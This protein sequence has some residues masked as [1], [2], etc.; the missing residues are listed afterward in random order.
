M[1][2]LVVGGHSFGGGTAIGSA[3]RDSRIKACVPMDPWLFPYE[4]EL[5]KL[6]LKNT[7]IFSIQ[8]WTWYSYCDTYKDCTHNC[9]KVTDDFFRNCKN[10]GNLDTQQVQIRDTVH[11]SQYDK[12]VLTPVEFHIRD[13]GLSAPREE[14]EVAD[15]YLLNS[16]LQMDFLLQVG[17]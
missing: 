15:L 7:P 6:I 3:V 11:S 2:K 16:W 17:M 12:A 1:D 13:N 4:K 14:K 10:K 9:K 5:H 8:S